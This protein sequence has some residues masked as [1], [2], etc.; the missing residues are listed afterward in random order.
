MVDIMLINTHNN[1]LNIVYKQKVT[2][3]K[4]NRKDKNKKVT[5]T[6]EYKEVNIPVELLTYWNSIL[7]C[8]EIEELF[9]VTYIVN[10]VTGNFI[11]PV[12]VEY[13]TDLSSF[14][15]NTEVPIVPERIISIPLRKHGKASN[16][17]YYIRHN[18][19][20]TF[21]EDYLTWVLNPYLKDPVLNTMG[22]VSVENRQVLTCD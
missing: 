5:K 21:T 22:L 15:N 1:F 6:Y 14:C 8:E 18:K 4:I 2:V 16:P 20:F 12:K 10:G 19:M 9:L 17:K 13:D 11:T 7:S 3:N